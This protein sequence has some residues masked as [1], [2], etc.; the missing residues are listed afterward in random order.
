MKVRAGVL[1]GRKG[2]GWLSGNLMLAFLGQGKCLADSLS[3]GLFGG[4]QEECKATCS[5]MSDVFSFKWLLV[6]PTSNPGN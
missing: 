5:D 6:S 2:L 4:S 1:R 3:H